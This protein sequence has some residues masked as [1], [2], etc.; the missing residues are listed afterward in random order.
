MLFGW[1]IPKLSPQQGHHNTQQPK[2]QTEYSLLGQILSR[3][4]GVQ[5]EHPFKWF[6]IHQEH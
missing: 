2:N 6:L 1:V 5:L 4:R 3:R